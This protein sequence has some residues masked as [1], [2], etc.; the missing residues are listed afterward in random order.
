MYPSRSPPRAPACRT[1]RSRWP[2]TWATARYELLD[3]AC[4]QASTLTQDLCARFLLASQALDAQ[5][6]ARFLPGWLQSDVGPQRALEVTGT[7]VAKSANFRFAAPYQGLEVIA[8]A[9]SVIGWNEDEAV[10]TP[11]DNCVLVMPSTRQA[12]A[13]VTVVRF[14]R[15]RKL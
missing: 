8:R 9:G 11:Y 5:S 10:T 7:V 6:I 4:R 14:A 2:A 3:A 12:K 15:R 1:T 13:G